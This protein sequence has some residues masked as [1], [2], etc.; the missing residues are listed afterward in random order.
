MKGRS[1]KAPTG[2]S[3]PILAIAG[4]T[5]T[6]KTDVAIAVA[7]GLDGEIISADSRQAYEGLAIGTAA[8]GPAELAAVPHHGVGFLDPGDRYGAG[9]FARLAREWIKDIRSRDRTPVLCGGSGFFL[10]GLSEPVFAEPP[11]D[12]ERRERLGRWLDEQ[13]PARLESW[14]RIVDP[15]AAER[16]TTVDPRRAARALEVALL[17]GRRLSSWQRRTPTE[18]TP[19]SL[20]V[21]VLELDAEAHRRR[22]RARSAALLDGGWLEEVEGLLDAGYDPNSPA[23][24]SIG[25]RTVTRLAAEEI[26]REQAVEAIIRDTWQY[27]R[28]QRTWFRHQ[29]PRDAVRLDAAM[30]TG[31]LAER[32]IHDWEGR[33]KR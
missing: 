21:Y 30:G 7:R 4:A 2:P 5:A 26:S 31:L 29:V 20:A 17:T 10:R 32:I 25:Y 18:A 33:V 24:T 6:G 16:L 8:P 22:I 11:L 13:E 28:R 1:S 27:A 23:L 15:D 9:Q 3:A 12:P 19:V 14:M